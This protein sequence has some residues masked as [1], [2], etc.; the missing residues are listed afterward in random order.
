[1]GNPV[2]DR[3]RRNL[4]GSLG[5]TLV[6]FLVTTIAN[7]VLLG[8]FSQQGGLE[9]IGR[10]TLML[11][12]MSFVFLIDYGFSDALTRVVSIKGPERALAI[13]LRLF[14]W[15]LAASLPATALMM[16]WAEFG[17]ER[18]E[19][20]WGTLLAAWAGVLQIASGWLVSLRLGQ[21]E[22]HWFYLK[23]LVRVL[24]QTTAAPAL[25]LGSDLDQALALGLALLLG[26]FSET[27]LTLIATRRDLAAASF[28]AAKAIPA[29]Q[30]MSVTSGFGPA[31]L[32]QRL[33]E[34][35]I[36]SLLARL[37][38]IDV[39]GSFTIVW[40]MPQTA[41]AAVSEGLRPLLPGLSH[42]LC[43][44]DTDKAARLIGQ[45]LFLQMVLSLPISLF[46]WIYAAPVFQVWLGVSDP[47][48]AQVTR[49]IIIGYA[50]I[51]LTVP[52]FWSLQ[53]YGSAGTIAWLTALNIAII[54]VVCVPALLF[55]EDAILT[56]AL[57]MVLSQVVFSLSAHT[58]CHRRW[59]LVQASYR[60]VP[61]WRVVALNGPVLAYNLALKTVLATT[62]GPIWLLILA[63][64]GS[65]ALYGAIWGVILMHSRRQ[66]IG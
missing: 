62:V 30:V 45:S 53:A 29:R 27:V 9:L 61:W 46:L 40:K 36:R 31:N 65:A 44:G 50:A 42:L 43:S 64:A 17:A 41:S 7:L 63:M 11:T 4:L 59:G 21:H 38:G 34:P 12:V 5:L 1:M 15:V 47:A 19:P 39:L 48:L 16:G 10:W 57:G 13:V 56:C 18:P 58:I 6:V 37:G 32:L 55:L 33:Q 24:T 54:A 14:G 22:Q 60:Q 8:W 28:A 3:I 66:A 52:F 25:M 35:V 26:G 2:F 51:N 23:T 20:I 49:V